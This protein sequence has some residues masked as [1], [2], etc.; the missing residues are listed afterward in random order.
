MIIV[1]IFSR[2]KI[3][4]IDIVMFYIAITFLN[5][6]IFKIIE[7]VSKLKIANSTIISTN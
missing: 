7:E 3:Y 2:S 4:F 5:Y 1:V 6:S